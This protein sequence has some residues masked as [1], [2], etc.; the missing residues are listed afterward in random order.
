MNPSSGL[1]APMPRF[2]TSLAI[3]ELMSS[4]GNRFT[5]S[6]KR[7]RSGL[8]DVRRIKR[9]PCGLDSTAAPFHDSSLR[10]RQKR[11]CASAWSNGP[12]CKHHRRRSLS[13]QPTVTQGEWTCNPRARPVAKCRRPC[14]ICDATHG[15]LCLERVHVPVLSVSGKMPKLVQ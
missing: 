1:K 13:A 14:Y 7:S 3:S 6:N 5:S 8:C 4:R 11:A 9:P 2:Q 10:S 15:S 12:L